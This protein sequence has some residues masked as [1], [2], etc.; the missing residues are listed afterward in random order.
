[1]KKNTHLLNK[2]V[3]NSCCLYFVCSY[4]STRNKLFD[5]RG[6]NCLVDMVNKLYKIVNERIE[7]MQQNERM[8]MTKPDKQRHT[9]DNICHLCNKELFMKT[10]TNSNYKVR[11]HDHRTREYRGPA[12]L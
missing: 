6:V 7:E 5:F 1:M 12:H 8:V 4:D 11:D 2:H 3:I 9:T 10:K